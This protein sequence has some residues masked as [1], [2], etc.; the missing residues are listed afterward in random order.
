ML[1]SMKT[2]EDFDIQWLDRKNSICRWSVPS[3]LGPH[4]D[5]V[6]DAAGEWCPNTNLMILSRT[7][8][9][10]WYFQPH[11]RQPDS[12][13]PATVWAPNSEAQASGGLAAAHTRR[14]SA[15]IGETKL[16]ILL[17]ELQ[18][19]TAV[20]CKKRSSNMWMFWWHNSTSVPL[21]ETNITRYCLSAD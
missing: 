2:L 19:I 3:T 6:F 17:E 16:T 20:P 21:K 13:S 10:D 1:C 7:E 14:R 18:N 11:D 15:I 8:W 5:A 12:I 9:S 4:T